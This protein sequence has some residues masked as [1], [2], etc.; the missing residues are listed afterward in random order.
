MRILPKSAL[1]IAAA[2]AVAGGAP[3]TGQVSNPNALKAAIVFNIMRYVEFPGKPASQPITLC[4]LRG[5]AGSGEF[6]GLNGQRAGNRQVLYRSFDGSS[7]AGCDAVFIGNG[8]SADIAR[9]RQRGTLVFGDGGGFTSAG[10]TVGL[11]RTGAQIRFEINL[12]TANETGVTISSHLLRLA[13][14]TVR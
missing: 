10:G 3:A 2:V 6:A 1:A 5:A 4:T 13:S 9:V 8:D 7:A 12:R 11:V 14:R